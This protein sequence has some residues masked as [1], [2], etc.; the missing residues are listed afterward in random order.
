[1]IKVVSTRTQI[2]NLKEEEKKVFE[3]GK[4]R[5]FADCFKRVIH[6]IRTEELLH[7]NKLEERLKE[8]VLKERPKK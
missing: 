5:G 7:N 3:L 8:F 1:L 6:F 4:R 2:K